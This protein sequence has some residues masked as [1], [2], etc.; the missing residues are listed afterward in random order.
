M[1]LE[2]MIG[3]ELSS[4][5]K[6]VRV[7]NERYE[8]LVFI[9][10]KD[11]NLHSVL[12]QKLG[13]AIN[14]NYKSNNL[15]ENEIVEAAIE[16]ANSNGGIDDDQFLYA[17]IYNSVTIVVMIWPWQNNEYMTIKKFIV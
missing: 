16:I 6:T 8:E 15:Q 9:N 12:T 1:N 14:G 2:T 3:E 11:S 5:I 13:A 7:N 17:G 4:F 10:S